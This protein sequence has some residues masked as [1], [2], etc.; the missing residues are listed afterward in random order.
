MAQFKKIYIDCLNGQVYRVLRNVIFSVKTHLWRLTSLFQ[1]E[2]LPAA[3][4]VFSEKERER[5]RIVR[6]GPRKIGKVIELL[7]SFISIQSDNWRG[8]KTVRLTCLFCFDSAA[9][10]ML[11]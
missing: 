6:K 11:N 9:L 2:S 10:L 7:I 1:F 8:S 4:A 5:E 3:A